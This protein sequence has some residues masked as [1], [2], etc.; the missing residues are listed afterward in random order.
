MGDSTGEKDERRLRNLPRAVLPGVSWRGLLIYHLLFLMIAAGSGAFGAYWLITRYDLKIPV[1][2]Q[3]VMIDLPEEL[4]VDVE[5]MEMSTLTKE[6]LAEKDM[7]MLPLRLS[8]SLDLEV[9]IDTMLPLKMTVPYKG[10]MPVRT[11]IPVDTVVR[12]KLLGMPLEM[13]VQTVVPVD[14]YVDVDVNIPIN[15]QVPLKFN[16]PVRAHIDQLVHIPIPAKQQAR[17]RM[18]KAEMPITIQDSEFVM[19]LSGVGLRKPD[20][21]GDR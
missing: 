21:E 18:E 7:V 1:S 2:N 6:E 11:M 20:A 16:A 19:P 13:P 3:S 12:T 17:I 10:S 15:Q 14:T 4:Q 5:L 8:D 9:N